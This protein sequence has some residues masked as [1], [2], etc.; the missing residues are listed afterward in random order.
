[1][2]SLARL[3]VG[4]EVLLRVQKEK[5][6]PEKAVLEVRDL[7][8]ADD[9]GLEAV[10]GLS[11]EARAGEIVGIAGVDGNGQAELVEAITGLRRPAAGSISVSGRDMTHSDARA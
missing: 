4:R 8:V 10:Q 3:M 5:A 9:R 11:L 7:H 6:H 2:E 1:E